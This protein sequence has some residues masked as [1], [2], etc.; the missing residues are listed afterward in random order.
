MRPILRQSERDAIFHDP[1]SVYVAKKWDE[2]GKKCQYCQD[3]P[4]HAIRHSEGMAYI[5]TC[6]QHL[7][8]GKKDAAA[9]V[10]FGGSDP[11]NIDS[12]KKIAGEVVPFKKHPHLQWLDQLPDHDWTQHTL[13]D[14]EDWPEDNHFRNIDAS[15]SPDVQFPGMDGLQDTGQELGTHKSQ[16]H[17]DPANGDKWLI[18]NTPASAPFLAHGDVATSAIQQHSGLPTPPTFLTQNAN[19]PASAQLMYPGA[20][21]AFPNKKVNPETLSDEDLMTIQKHHALDWMISN[22]DAHGGQFIRDQQ[23]KLIGID[24]G[25]AFRY[26]NQDRLSHNFHP[27]SYYGEQEPVYNTLYRNYAQGGRQLNDPRQG[28]LGAFIQHLQDTPDEEYRQTLMPY[29]QQA[30]AKGSLGSYNDPDSY[31]G[32]SE[33]QKFPQNDPEAFLQHAVDRKNNLMND[34][35]DLYDRASAYRMT[36]TKIALRRVGDSAHKDRWSPGETA[37]FEYHCLM[38]PSSSDY[39]LWQRTQQPVKVLGLHPGGDDFSK[40]LPTFQ[41]RGNEGVPLTYKVQFGDGHKAD[42]MEDELLTHPKHYSPDYAFG[43]QNLGKQ[44]ARQ[45]MSMPDPHQMLKDEDYDGDLG[46]H[47]GERWLD[48]QG[49]WML[50]R[51]KP[52]NEFMV[53]QE[54]GISALQRRAGLDGPE[55]HAVP[56]GGDVV[57]ASKWYPNARQA[58]GGPTGRGKPPRFSD[59]QPGDLETIQKHQALDWLIGNHDAHVGNWMRKDDGGLV[60][61]DKGQAMKYYGRDRLDPNFHPNYYAREPIYNSLWRQ[62]IRGEGQMSDPRQGE[63]GKFVQ[64]LQNIPDD[65][66]KGMF[67]PYAHAATHAGMLAT[68]GPEDSARKLGRPTIPANDPDAFLGAMVDRKNSLGRDLG[69]LYDKANAA[70]KQKA[71]SQP[72]QA[73]PTQSIQIDHPQDDGLHIG[74]IHREGVGL[75]AIGQG[76]ATDVANG[77]LPKLPTPPTVKAPAAP[78]QPAT[79]PGM[80]PANSGAQTNYNPH[81]DKGYNPAAQS[82]W[83]ALGISTGVPASYDATQSKLQQMD[84]THHHFQYDHP[85]SGDGGYSTGI[86]GPKTPGSTP[87]AAEHMVSPSGGPSTPV[88]YTPSAGAEQWNDQVNLALDRNGL[89]RSL[90]PNVKKQIGTESSGNPNAINNDDS[91]AVAGHPSQGL[92]QTIPSTFQHYHLPGDSNSITDPQANLDAAIGY[93]KETYGPTLMNSQGT[94]IGSG[95]GY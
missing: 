47:G 11:S 67:A 84:P 21:D 35:G 56:M 40:D 61:I 41:E 64:G 72:A 76:L 85:L 5:Q 23:G 92:L 44:G 66:L 60:G 34:M 12:V 57:T 16:V 7:T 86:G 17:A 78:T 22:H 93:A 15:T 30:A 89:P 28:E 83:N 33:E 53:P 24:K 14:A 46:S 38:D 54:V 68:G 4:T 65:E 6:D 69:H 42:A 13:G 95:R 62:H 8:K 50:K 48:P 71:R 59:L 36:G 81:G 3:S 79:M 20:K 87:G 55:T 2:P 94:G 32:L 82:G 90:A 18:K 9:C 26:V 37:H 74:A 49:A 39:N 70:R 27:N 19:K 73:Q 80:A 43:P 10:P 25:Q 77:S 1:P 45:G 29:A 52:G 88:S 31:S 91:N 75:P 63:L 58:F 51:P